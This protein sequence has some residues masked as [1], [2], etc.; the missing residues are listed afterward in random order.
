[1]VTMFDGNLPASTVADCLHAA[2]YELE[3]RLVPLEA[4]DGAA[5]ETEPEYV[6]IANGASPPASRT[7]VRAS[8]GADRL[9][10]RGTE[11]PSGQQAPGRRI[12]LSKQRE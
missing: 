5:R 7:S 6:S 12:V 8:P 11:Q 2:G 1:M 10:S 4:A 3:L 9:P